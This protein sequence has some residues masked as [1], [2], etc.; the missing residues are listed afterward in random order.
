ML[1]NL[2]KYRLITEMMQNLAEP[3]QTVW[4]VGVN[5]HKYRGCYDLMQLLNT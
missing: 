1:H 2:I 3:F 4:I 5:T